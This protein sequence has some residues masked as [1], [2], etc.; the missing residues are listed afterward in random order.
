MRKMFTRIFSLVLLFCMVGFVTELKAQ[1]DV[2][3]TDAAAAVTDIVCGGNSTGEIK[4]FSA[5]GG[6]G[7]YTYTLQVWEEGTWVDVTP[8]V[9]VADTVYSA[10]PYGTYKVMVADS[11]G[12]TAETANIDVAGMAPE[13]AVIISDNNFEDMSCNGAGDGLIEIWAQG[14]SGTYQFKINNNSWRDFPTGSSYKDIAVTEVGEYVI[15][16]RD[17]LAPECTTESITF[18]IGEPAPVAVSTAA[19]NVNSVCNPDGAFTVTISGGHLGEGYPIDYDVYVNDELWSSNISGPSVTYTDLPAGTYNVKVIENWGGEN[20]CEGFAT[21]ELTAPAAI[22]GIATVSKNVLCNGG[23]NGE[24]MVSEVAGGTAPYHLYLTGPVTADMVYDATGVNTFTGLVAGT[25]SVTIEDAVGCEFPID[26]L[27]VEE[28]SALMLNTTHIQDIVCIEDGKF[29]VQVSGG[30]GSYKYYAALSQLPEYITVPDAGS[31]EWQTDSIFTVTEPGTYFVWAMDVNE[32]IIGGEED[33]LGDPV[34]AWTVQIEKPEIEVFVDATVMNAP[35]C[36]GDLTGSVS[37]EADDVVIYKDG[38]KVENPVYT[39]TINEDE[40]NKLDNLGA[41]TYYIVVTSENGCIGRD[42]VIFTEPQVLEAVLDKAEGEFVCP[43]ANI[44]Y[45]ETAVTGGTEGTGFMYQLWQNNV[46]KTDYQESNSFLV[47]IDNEYTVVVMDGNGCTDTSNVVK[48]DPV[49]PIEFELTDVSCSDDT[50]ASAWVEVAFE[51]GRMYQVLWQKLETE[52][53]DYTDTSV[54]FNEPIKLDQKFAFSS[55]G[56][57][58]LYQFTVVDDK[59][60]IAEVM[61]MK[62]DQVTALELTI[63][64]GDVDGCTTGVTVVAAGGVAPYSLMVNGEVATGTEL[65]LGGGLH[66]IIVTDA[67]GCMK[68]TVLELAYPISMD[69]LIS[70]YVGDT[71]QFVYGTIDTMLV[72]EVEGETSHKLYNDIE[73][74]CIEEVVV[75]LDARERAM[76]VLDSVSPNGV[77]IETNHAVFTIVFTDEIPITFNESVD[78]YITVTAV[79][80]TEATLVIPITADMVDGNTITVDYDYMVVGALA[81]NT[82]YTVAVDSGIVMGDGMAWNGVTGDW[83]FTTGDDYPLG[84]EPDFK[85]ADFKVYPN[86]FNEFIRID[87]ASELDRVVIS[88]IAGQRVLDIAYPEYEIPTGNLNAGV[89]IITLSADGEVVKSV[90]LIKR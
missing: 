1:C 67:H 10:L 36:N 20:S 6:T 12:C 34:E 81:I 50:M 74:G 55:E 28:P 83:T 61:T 86:P 58:T 9:G 4:V 26:D 22:S 35:A 39:V 11:E 68:D 54:W 43:G 5:E 52:A 88:N 64:E 3:I 59:G 53:G 73:A 65:S 48:I 2:T 89:Y 85:V 21:A 30:A 79:D 72:A 70:V 17:V 69:T 51:E 62:F 25:Y 38:L 45:I 78:G 44:G 29:S 14:G 32:C 47:A 40:T 90:R 80:S 24:I 31:V 66:D 76:P 37:V 23:A 13:E 15:Q 33:S 56:N 63:T 75:T 46:L 49:P 71:T 16:V 77:T 87:K 42:T 7:E 84:T 82:S 60:C 19:D 57:D 27:M 41:G 18:I 8:Y